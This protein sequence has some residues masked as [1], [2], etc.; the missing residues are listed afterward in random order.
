MHITRIDHVSLNVSD[1]PASVA[2]YESVLGLPVSRRH[3]TPDSPVFLGEN[4]AQLGLFAEPPHGLR[5]VALGISAEDHAALRRRLE[6][7]GIGFVVERHGN[8]ESIYFKDPDGNTLEALPV[9]PL[10]DAV[11]VREALDS[12]ADTTGVSPLGVASGAGG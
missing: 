3:A 4:G 9:E 12:L 11:A 6:E 2:W 10:A 1:R 7:L 8:Y 5:H